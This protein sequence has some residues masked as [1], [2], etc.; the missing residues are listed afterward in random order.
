MQAELGTLGEQKTVTLE[1]KLLADIGLVGLPNAGKSTLLS[2]ITRAN[3]KTADYPFTTLEPNLGVLTLPEG[4]D[5]V[6]A[7]IPGLIEGAHQGKGLGHD[8]L[9]HIENTLALVFVLF[10]EESVVFDEDLTA[11]Q[12]A[13][14]VWAQY[15][16]LQTE[17]REYQVDLLAK[18]SLIALNKIDLYPAELVTAIE[19]EFKKTGKEIY[20]F[21]GFTGEG[22]IVLINKL[23]RLV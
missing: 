10:L 7:D 8:F 4:K 22:L 16:Q 14:L 21:S 1:L 20:A 12:K 11:E 13:D 6:V 15:Q 17:L 19:K 23:A 2:K 3:P 5:L 18:P 9:R